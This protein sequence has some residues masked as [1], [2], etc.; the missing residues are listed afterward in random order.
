MAMATHEH[1]IDHLDQP[2][3]GPPIPPGP[4]PVAAAAGVHP[5]RRDRD[6][7]ALFCRAFRALT[8]ALIALG[9]VALVLW[10]V[11]QPSSLKAHVDSAQLTRFDLAVA[12][13]GTRLRFDL[14]VGVSIRNP[15]RKQAVLFR[16]LEAVALYGGKRFGH[17]DLPSMRQPRKSTAEVRPSFRGEAAV[18]SGGAAAALFAREKAEGFFGFGVKF[19]TRVRL[20]EAVVDSVEYRPEVD[21]YIR[22]PDPS[23]ATAV[24]QGFTPTQCHVDDFS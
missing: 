18:V 14:T 22:V 20:K 2:Y 16:R 1:K 5:P 3:Y 24:A 11:Y 9:V 15:N 23:N 8:L 19:R 6:T 10:L 13:N 7:Y 21:C 4:A 17:A 12:A